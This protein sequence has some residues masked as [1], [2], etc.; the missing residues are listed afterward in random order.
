MWKGLV[1]LARD[2]E[3]VAFAKDHNVCCLFHAARIIQWVSYVREICSFMSSSGSTDTCYTQYVFENDD[4]ISSDRS[5]WNVDHEGIPS[6]ESTLNVENE[7]QLFDMF[8]N[9]LYRAS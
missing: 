8:L 6:D 4:E 1:A 7:N 9:K 3:L 5:T 2:Q